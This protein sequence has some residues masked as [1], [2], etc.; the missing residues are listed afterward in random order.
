[1]YSVLPTESNNKHSCSP[2][3]PENNN[4]SPLKSFPSPGP[5][6]C[7]ALPKAPTQACHISGPPSALVSLSPNPVDSFFKEDCTSTPDMSTQTLSLP[8]VH[9]RPPGWPPCL[10]SCPRHP[11]HPLSLEAPSE[12]SS[13]PLVTCSQWLPIACTLCPTAQLPR[14]L[15]GLIAPSL[16]HTPA[17]A[18]PCAL[19]LAQAGPLPEPPPLFHPSRLTLLCPQASPGCRRKEIVSQCL[20]C[21]KL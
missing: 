14:Y 6:C 17:P 19:A 10:P 8:P 2:T 13:I 4:L 20:S 21:P 16:K 1:M 12:V 18:S 3:A 7:Q 11:F 15:S 5:Q 9:C